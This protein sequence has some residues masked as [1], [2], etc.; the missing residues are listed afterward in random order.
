MIPGPL[1]EAGD[2]VKNP[3]MSTLDFYYHR[4]S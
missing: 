2:Y 3:F 1:C 4:P